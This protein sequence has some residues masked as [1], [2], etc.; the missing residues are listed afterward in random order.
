VNSG[1]IVLQCTQNCLDMPK[2]AALRAPPA[3]LYRIML[4]LIVPAIA[5]VMAAPAP[6]IV[7]VA[8][9]PAM[10]ITAIVRPVVVTIVI[11]IAIAAAIIAV[12][13]AEMI[14]AAPGAEAET[15]ALRRSGDGGGGQQRAAGQGD[16]QK[17]FHHLNS[18]VLGGFPNLGATMTAAP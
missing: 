4:D 2:P 10:A 15:K 14:A 13:T 16:F 11:A 17:V 9:A 5:P 12:I 7:P 6:V 8:M 1:N 3:L 18:L